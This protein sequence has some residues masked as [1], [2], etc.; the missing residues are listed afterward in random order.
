MVNFKFSKTGNAVF[1]SHHDMMRLFLLALR[2][3]EVK[4]DSTKRGKLK[5]YFSP[6][7]S[8]GTHSNAEFVQISSNLTA[9]KV[10]D[11]IETYLP[12]GIKIIKEFDTDER[13]NIASI[14]R[15]AKYEIEIEE[16]D[17]LE[18]GLSD[19]LKSERFKVSRK[20]NGKIYE[21]TPAKFIHNFYFDKNKL[22]ILSVVGDEHINIVQTIAQAL[23]KLGAKDN[24]FK[25]TKT[26][27]FAS[28]DNR[29]H[30]IELMLIRSANK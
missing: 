6:A 4:I 20:L 17:K 18:K 26:N 30:D 13:I 10:A 25:I 19:L 12:A 21:D 14:A 27:I 1:L 29:Y 16:I 7:T 24:N 9:H 23:N 11:M 3:A 5:V 28:F 8:I 2:R 15:L 22:Y